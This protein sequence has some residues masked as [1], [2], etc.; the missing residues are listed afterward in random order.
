MFEKVIIPEFKRKYS[1]CES[2][3]LVY[4][5]NPVIAGEERFRGFILNKIK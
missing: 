5:E 4:N 2:D 3:S 1:W